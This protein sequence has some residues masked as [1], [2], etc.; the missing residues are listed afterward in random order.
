M[1]QITALGFSEAAAA[2]FLGQ[3]DGDV[4]RA[5]NAIL[6]NPD[7]QPPRPDP[8]AAS[9]AE[10]RRLQ[11][12]EW[13]A[14]RVR[15]EE[16][17]AASLA[18]AQQ[19]V[20]SERLQGSTRS[21]VM[22]AAAPDLIDLWAEPEPE[23]QLQAGAPPPPYSVDPPPAQTQTQ[24]RVPVSPHH[25][26]S[27]AVERDAALAAQ[28]A[29]QDKIEALERRLAETTRK[30]ISQQEVHALEKEEITRRL[31]QE[32]EDKQRAQRRWQRDQHKVR[33]AELTA[34]EADARAAALEEVAERNAAEKEE[35]QAAV[36]R[37]A[38]ADYLAFPYA[39]PNLR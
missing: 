25:E 36:R 5:V 30:M 31:Q 33:R 29:Q 19:L 28:L 7:W 12:A 37:N 6:A 39:L 22:T 27:K 34:A 26:H 4:H 15:Q 2:H 38:A 21:T 14:Q 20:E 13:E 32:L 9:F 17:E 24:A 3:C 35:L 8:E 10:A 18:L 16:D 11:E 1:E 23:P